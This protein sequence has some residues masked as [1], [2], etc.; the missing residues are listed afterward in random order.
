MELISRKTAR[1][2]YG[3]PLLGNLLDAVFKKYQGQNGVR[4]NAKIRVSSSAE[5]QRLQN[6]FGNRLKRLIHPGTEVEVPLKVFAEELQ[7]GYR[8]SIPELY[9]VLKGEMLLTKLEQRQLKEEAWTQIFIK[10]RMELQEKTEVDLDNEVFRAET[11]D[12]LKRLQEGEASGYHVLRSAMNRE[13]DAVDVLFCCL[14]GLW[15]LLIDKETMLEELSINVEKVRIPVFAAYVTPTRDPHGFDWKETAGRLLWYALHDIDKQRIKIGQKLAS[16]KLMVPEYMQRRQV[17]RNFGLMDDDISSF[18]NVF[19]PH[20]VVGN[21]PRTLNL[22]EIQSSEDFPA[23]SALYAFENPA[24]FSHV[25]DELIHF[26]DTNGLSLEQIPEK[27]PA[28]ICTS[29][30]PRSATL[31]FITKCLEANPHC[32]V[33]Y[34]GDLDLQGV[35]MMCEVERQFTFNFEAV[36]MDDETYRKHGDVNHLLLSFQ[37]KAVLKRMGEGV[38]KVM[39]ELGVKV[40]QEELVK[41]LTED[42]LEAI[43]LEGEF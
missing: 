12:W 5:A 42:V 34:S 40:Y 39:V 4:G 31:E 13:E 18:F 20:F 27:F 43:R 24:V 28:L 29:G 15:H 35:Q 11:F 14:K 8:L 1:Q 41:D 37:D 9:E 26:L 10:V 21:S 2:Y 36:R 33:R 25:I 16:E 17:Y 6:Y 30:Q 32:P 23:Y 22:R 7:L 3:D 19:A 38:S